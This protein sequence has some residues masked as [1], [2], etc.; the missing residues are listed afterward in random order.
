MK[1]VKFVMLLV[2]CSMLFTTLA[3]AQERKDEWKDPNIILQN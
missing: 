2:L 3:A 1:Y